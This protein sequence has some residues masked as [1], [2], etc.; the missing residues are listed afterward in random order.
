MQ[1]KKRFHDGIRRGD[2]VVTYRAWRHARVVEASRYRVPP[3]G[4]IQ[5]DRISQ[6]SLGSLGEADALASGFESLDALKQELQRSATR[7][8]TRRSKIFRVD[9][10]FAG[11]LPPE[12]VRE[13]S[14]EAIAETHQKLSR[15]DQRSQRGPWTEL[16]L[17][18][19]D[20]NPGVAARELS[21]NLDR[22]LPAFKTD[23]RKLKRLG[24][25]RSLETGY[26]LTSLGKALIGRADDVPEEPGDP[27]GE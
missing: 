16:A 8:I 1:F 15:M 17:Q 13:T 18:M 24:L 5:V 4:M 25:T 10:H 20:E 23:V 3:A 14:A 12:P 2:I 6:V 22:E 26:E 9:F 21:P 27:E 19:I 11:E 7:R